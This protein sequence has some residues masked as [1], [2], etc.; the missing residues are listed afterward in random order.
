MSTRTGGVSPPPLGMN[1]SF[2]VGDLQENVRRNRAIFFGG[3][4]V[5][6]DRLALQRQVHGAKVQVVRSP[7]EFPETDALV[8]AEPRVFL[9]VSIAD[10]VPILLLDP[11]RRVV[12]AVHAGWR[13]T[14]A[15]IVGE[16][17]RTMSR[18]FNCDPR[19]LLAYIGPAADRCCYAVGQEVASSFPGESLSHRDGRIYLD[20]KMSNR[21][22][23]LSEG[24][25]PHR[26]SVSPYCT[27]SDATLFHS[28]R[29][30]GT[31][32]GRM[33]AVIGLTA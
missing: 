25:L 1:L 9:C 26:I 8:T 18:E 24:M 11:V 32:S 15:G 2:S 5:P 3:I 16:A 27:I 13:G 17:V 21:G 4:G 7:G 30:E 6:L 31:K 28:H 33:M 23:L 20:L 22:Q 29:R 19:S 14:A 10:C 12:G